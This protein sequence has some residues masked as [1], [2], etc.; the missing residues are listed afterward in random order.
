MIYV[1]PEEPVSGTHVYST[2]F[3]QLNGDP[4]LS[5]TRI[6]CGSCLRLMSADKI[7]LKDIY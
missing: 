6:I 1:N 7:R 2:H 4:C 5:G 3:T